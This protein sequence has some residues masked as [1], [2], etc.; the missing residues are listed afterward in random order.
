VR[1]A[2]TLNVSAVPLQPC[3]ALRVVLCVPQYIAHQS[4]FSR[5]TLRKALK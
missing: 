2:H 1:D 4:V 3:F 5:I